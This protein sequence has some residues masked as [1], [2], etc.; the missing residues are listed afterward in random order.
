MPTLQA[1]HLFVHC[2]RKGVNWVRKQTRS[3]RFPGT[4]YWGVMLELKFFK[5]KKMNWGLYKVCEANKKG[6]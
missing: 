6:K 4:G 1:E 3:M 5:A 2:L